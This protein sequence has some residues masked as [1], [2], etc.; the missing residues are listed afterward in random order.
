VA[1]LAIVRSAGNRQLGD[2]QAEALDRAALDQ[3]DRLKRLHR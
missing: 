3:R 1:L 2:S